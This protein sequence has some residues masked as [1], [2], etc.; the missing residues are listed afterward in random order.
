MHMFQPSCFERETPIL[1]FDLEISCFEPICPN[2]QFFVNIPICITSYF[3]FWC[4]NCII[5]IGNTENC[6]S[7]L[8]A[9]FAVI[10]HR[11]CKV[12]AE[13]WQNYTIFKLILSI[14]VKIPQNA[15]SGLLGVLKSK[16]FPSVAPMVPTQVDTGF[17]TNLTFQAP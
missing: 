2:F 12:C 10:H 5:A 4:F 15:F 11:F 14:Y 7:M 16:I 17:I 1:R 13:K 8:T 3:I 6:R 9:C